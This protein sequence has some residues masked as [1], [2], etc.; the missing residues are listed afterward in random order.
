MVTYF[1]PSGIHGLEARATLT[2]SRG[3]GFQPVKLRSLLH[4]APVA[5]YVTLFMKPCT[6]RELRAWYPV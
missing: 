1:R 4:S 6:K 5:E 2:G 3:T